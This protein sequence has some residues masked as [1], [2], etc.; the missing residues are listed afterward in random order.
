[1]DRRLAGFAVLLAVI[2]AAPIVP[3]LGGQHLTGSAQRMPIPDPPVVGDCLSHVASQPSAMILSLPVFAEQAGSCGAGNVGEIVA[4]V[5]KVYFS[6]PTLDNG[7][8]VAQAVD[9]DPLVRDYLGWSPPTDASPGNA[10]E[11]SALVQWHPP[12][13]IDSGLLGPDLAQ[14]IYGQRWVACVVYPEFVPFRGSIRGGVL[15]GHNA[16]ALA[17]CQATPDGKA[18]QPISCSQ[19]HRAE[20]FGVVA[21]SDQTADLEP[22]CLAL[23]HRLTGMSDVSSSGALIVSAVITSDSARDNASTLHPVGPQEYEATCLSTVV[24]SR[25]LVGTLIGLGDRSLPWQ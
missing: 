9:C 21:V 7:S 16:D 22:S 13:T 11:S 1:M 19:P 5:P 3:A 4:V 25:L 23:V 10:S 6:P 24:G 18:L 2:I 14:Y 15:D 17:S 8:T 20:T 12:R